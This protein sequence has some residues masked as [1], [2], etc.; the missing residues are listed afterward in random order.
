MA[1]KQDV[2]ISTRHAGHIIH[3]KL[4]V[5]ANLLKVLE[6]CTLIS[7]QS[8]KMKTIAFLQHNIL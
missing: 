6:K 2:G 1:M 8:I 7:K 5:I 4:N 3:V